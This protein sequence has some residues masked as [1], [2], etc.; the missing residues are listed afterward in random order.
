MT[1]REMDEIKDRISRFLHTLD[2]P[3]PEIQKAINIEPMGIE[4]AMKETRLYWF[5]IYATELISKLGLAYPQVNT[6]WLKTGE[7]QMLR[8]LDQNKNE[9]TKNVID[10][11]FEDQR[12]LIEDLMRENILQRKEIHALFEFKEKVERRLK[13]MQEHINS[14]EKKIK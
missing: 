10:P 1:E 4:M 5:P 7:G 8:R 11:I 12:Q 6:L 2:K 9:I 14:L 3:L 13:V